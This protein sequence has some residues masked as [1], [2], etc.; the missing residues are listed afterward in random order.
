MNDSIPKELARCIAAGSKDPMPRGICPR[1]GKN[2]ALVRDQSRTIVHGCSDEDFREAGEG[3][4]SVNLGIDMANG[5]IVRDP[6]G[7]AA[8]GY[9]R[10]R[11]LDE[12]RVR[13]RDGTPTE[14]IA[15][16]TA[17]LRDF[18]SRGRGFDWIADY[19][20]LLVAL[21]RQSLSEPATER[22]CCDLAE[23]FCPG[24]VPIGREAFNAFRRVLGEPE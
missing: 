6:H 19:E 21:A 14:S 4:G 24:F 17:D 13:L 18:L 5:T 16:V 8:A 15:S 7:A 2:V 10:L 20:L 1:C 12:L 9:G 11:E 22:H 3:G 23:K